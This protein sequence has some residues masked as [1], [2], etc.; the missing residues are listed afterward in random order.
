M[1]WWQDKQDTM[2]EEVPVPK[3]PY[4][5]DGQKLTLPDDI[6]QIKRKLHFTLDTAR[7]EF[8]ETLAIRDAEIA[9]LY[10]ELRALKGSCEPQP[11]SATGWP[12]SKTDAIDAL[13]SAVVAQTALLRSISEQIRLGQAATDGALDGIASTIGHFYADTGEALAGLAER[14]EKME[15]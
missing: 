5:E 6:Y 8:R 9:R 7:A 4:F 1:R 12:E 13:R 14:L 2:S 11:D 15:T 3:V 10:S